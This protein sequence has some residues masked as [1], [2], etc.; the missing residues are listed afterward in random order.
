VN[1]TDP[2]GRLSFNPLDWAKSAV[3]AVYDV[4]KAVYNAGKAAYNAVRSAAS[5]ANR[6]AS[7]AAKKIGSSVSNAAKSVGR[8]MSKLTSAYLSHCS[9]VLMVTKEILSNPGKYLGVA[10]SSFQGFCVGFTQGVGNFVT[11]TVKGIGDLATGKIGVSQFLSGMKDSLVSTGKAIGNINLAVTDPYAYG[12]SIGQITGSIEAGL[13]FSAACSY[14]VKNFISPAISRAAAWVKAKVASSPTLSAIAERLAGEGG[15][16]R[17]PFGS[18]GGPLHQGKIME[19]IDELVD[20]DYIHKA[21]GSL[22]EE[23]I[24][25]DDGFKSSRRPDITMLDPEGNIYYENVGRATKSGL[26]VAREVRAI[27]N[28]EKTTGVPVQYTPYNR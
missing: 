1:L 15:F 13:A 23:V 19:R 16:I 24:T 6:A 5:W 18:K 4:G 28:I 17:N 12:R 25:I 3:N 27:Q 14:V 26:P 8:T 22:K 10:A 7:D 9:T 2:T 21:G 20:Q 11:S